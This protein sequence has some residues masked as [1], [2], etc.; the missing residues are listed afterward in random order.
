MSGVKKNC[1]DNCEEKESKYTELYHIMRIL[2]V[3]FDK[4]CQ[5]QDD[6][7]KLHLEYVDL[8][9]KIHHKLFKHH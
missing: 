2:S 7:N 6:M 9:G 5:V 3:F 4:C 1:R 8:L